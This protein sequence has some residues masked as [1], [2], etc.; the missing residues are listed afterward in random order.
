MNAHN[1]LSAGSGQPTQGT[2][3]GLAQTQP[4]DGSNRKRKRTPTLSIPAED[5]SNYEPLIRHSSRTEW[6]FLENHS[7]QRDKLETAK[8]NFY[9]TYFLKKPE[10]L[11]SIGLV[12]PKGQSPDSIIR[13]YVTVGFKALPDTQR[14][15]HRK[16]PSATVTLAKATTAWHQHL[17]R[18]G[19][20]EQR[21]IAAFVPEKLHGSIRNA[22]RD[23][24][25][26]LSMSETITLDL[27]IAELLELGLKKEMYSPSPPNQ[28]S[29]SPEANPPT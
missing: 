18:S 25:K 3:I 29:I 9:I 12:I 8:M 27:F 19:L 14:N 13:A 1:E 21:Q 4:S 7:T 5:I 28:G 10:R 2:G 16:R 23:R 26:G 20:I 11:P 15:N 24:L 22:Y 17:K 6:R